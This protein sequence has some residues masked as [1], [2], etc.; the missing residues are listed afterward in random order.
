MFYEL[1]WDL[2][3]T[4]VLTYWQL[5]SDPDHLNFLLSSGFEQEFHKVSTPLITFVLRHSDK[6]LQSYIECSL[7]KMSLNIFF[8]SNFGK[9]IDSKVKAEL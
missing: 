5:I 6:S 7:A 4:V 9:S 8:T 2:R 3:F 1:K